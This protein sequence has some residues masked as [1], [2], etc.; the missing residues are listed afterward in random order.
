MN[1]E[2]TK[3]YLKRYLKAR[4][5]VICINTI[6]K[7]RV[8]RILNEISDEIGYVF[9][10]FQMSQGISDLKTNTIVSE[11]KTIMSALEYV[12]SQ[13]KHQE[14]YNFILGDIA[15]ITESSMV[16][17]YL[18]NVIE[19]AEKKSGVII[20]ISNEPIWSSILR[21]G[22]SLKLAYPTE[23]E[24]RQ[25]IVKTI[26]PYT[27]QIT[28]EWDESD[29]SKAAT[30]LQ[31]LSEMEAKNIISSLIVRGAIKKDDLKE[32]KYAKQSLFNEIAGLEAIE[33]SDDFEIAGLD[34]LKNWLFC[35][36]QLQ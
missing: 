23:N 11:D 12:S 1:Y 30:Y 4:I 29:Y 20:I 10:L 36:I 2:E 7:N 34:N 25:E 28:V 16:S 21:L 31:G 6:E 18:A 27:T 14:N 17:R 15:D 13:I 8:I 24:L 35:L 3:E 33:V 5:P 9:N 32:L 22:I 26:K 19:N